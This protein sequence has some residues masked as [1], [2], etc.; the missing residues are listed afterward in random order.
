MRV[1]VILGRVLDPAGIVVNRRVNRIFIN[2][3]TYMMQPADRCALEAAL[4]IQDS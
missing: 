4:R 3:E 1:V 2:R